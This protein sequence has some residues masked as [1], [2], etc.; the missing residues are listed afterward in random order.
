[1][2]PPTVIAIFGVVC[3]GALAAFLLIVPRLW[4]P[5]V[6]FGVSVPTEGTEE[7]RRRA[8]RFWTISVILLTAAAIGATLLLAKLKPEM[9][10]AQAFIVPYVV[11]A[12]LFYV[13]ARRMLLPVA[14][15]SGKVGAALRRRRY[16]DYMSPWWDVI[17]A[18]L[19]VLGLVLSAWMVLRP[20]RAAGARVWELAST[21]ALQGAIIAVMV[22]Y[23]HLLLTA[24]LM[25]HAKQSIGGGDAAVSLAASEAFRKVWIRYMYAFRLWLAAVFV[26]IPGCLALGER[27]LM[28]IMP[29]LPFLHTAL[30]VGGLT[31]LLAGSWVITLRY[32]QGGWRWAVRQGL[33]DKNQV[34][35]ILD[36]DGM[37]DDR[38]KL[39]M[40]YFN[41]SDPSIL[42]ER[43]FGV[44][45]TLNLGNIWA[46]VLIFFGIVGVC[47]LPSLLSVVLRP[48]K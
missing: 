32:G 30:V 15:P 28:G 6:P 17:P 10:I 47:L 27:G 31:L 41:P 42:V 12:V 29:A 26:I 34:A 21:E 38:W 13:S 23:P 37:Q 39:G 40:F 33:V 14:R 18:G 19:V 35:A 36:G 43:R 44:G 3:F 48:I 4:R 24:V 2:T 16:R 8:L 1:M 22:V 45:W 25:A 20:S 5:E 9:W 46:I 7:V 11:L